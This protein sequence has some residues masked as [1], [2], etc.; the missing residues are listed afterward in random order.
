MPHYFATTRQ[1]PAGS[2]AWTSDIFDRAYV[3]NNGPFARVMHRLNLG[4]S[5]LVYLPGSCMDAAA[6]T[7]TTH[8]DLTGKWTVLGDHPG[9]DARMDVIWQKTTKLVGTLLNWLKESSGKDRPDAIFKNLDRLFADGTTQRS[10]IQDSG[11][12]VALFSLI[13]STRTARTLGLADSAF[14]KLPDAVESAFTEISWLDEVSVEN[15]EYLIPIELAANLLDFRGEDADLP[16]HLR[17][18]GGAVWLLAS[19]LRWTDPTRAV[20][21]LQSVAKSAQRGVLAATRKQISEATIPIGFTP[22]SDSIPAELETLQHSYS[23]AIFDTLQ[24]EVIAKFKQWDELADNPAAD[25][26]SFEAALRRQ[27]PGLVLYGPP[28]TGKTYL[29]RWIAA[30]LKLPIRVVS[31]ALLRGSGFGE[32]ERNI[33]RLLREARRAAPCVLVLDDADDLLIDRSKIQGSVAGVERAIVNTMLQQL[34]GFDGPLAGVLVVVTTNKFDLI[35]KAIKDRLTCHIRVTYPLTT[36]HVK[37]IVRTIAGELGYEFDANNQAVF[38]RLIARFMNF[39]LPGVGNIAVT[40]EAERARQVDGLFS[41]REIQHAM[42]L[43]ESSDGRGD[44]PKARYR[45]TGE[46]VDRME[47]YFENLALSPELQPHHKP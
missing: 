12:R 24:S 22:P 13:E 6:H 28:G 44:D 26:E 10:F 39:V 33:V 36:G 31:G 20:R 38:A 5:Q 29:A 42:R 40:T 14:G 47:R 35:D 7:V 37:T 18:A 16:G 46:D 25:K 41:P 21:I 1:K 15:F 32:S 8:H 9:D 19:R 3:K 11:A 43:L 27:T 45:P 30:V 2:L 23:E 4:F 17:I 34:Q